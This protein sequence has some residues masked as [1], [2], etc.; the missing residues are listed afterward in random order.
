MNRQ[1]PESTTV[2]D[3]AK[4]RDRE[5]EKDR[6]SSSSSN[7]TDHPRSGPGPGPGMLGRAFGSFLPLCSVFREEKHTD[8]ATVSSISASI[9]PFSAHARFHHMGAASGPVE[10]AK[11]APRWIVAIR[12][13]VHL[14]L[15]PVVDRMSV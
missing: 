8:R 15:L 12:T 13:T 10:I 4:E 7:A 14:A 2:K 11:R 1:S 3:R 6:N 5:K 9:H